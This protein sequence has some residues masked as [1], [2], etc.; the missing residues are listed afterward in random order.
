[1]LSMLPSLW[2]SESVLLPIQAMVPRPSNRYSTVID[3]AH[4]RY[5]RIDNHAP[6]EILTIGSEQW[7]VMPWLRKNSAVRN[8]GIAATAADVHSGTLGWAVRYGEA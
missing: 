2:N 8:G 3:C 5:M 7:M 1:M 6:F 4:A